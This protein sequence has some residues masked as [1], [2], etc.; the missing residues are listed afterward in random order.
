MKSIIHRSLGIT[1][2]IIIL[3]AR[4]LGD[5]VTYTNYPPLPPEPPGPPCTSR[6]CPINLTTGS[7]W[8]RMTD[9]AIP[10][11]G[12]DLILVRTYSS[13]MTLENMPFGSG[14]T[15][16]LDPR[17]LFNQSGE[18]HFLREDGDIIQLRENVINRLQEQGL[19]SSGS[20]NVKIE[21]VHIPVA[22]PSI[23]DEDIKLA[24]LS[25]GWRLTFPGFVYMDFNKNGLIRRKWNAAGQSLEFIRDASNRL[26]RV[27]HNCG[28]SIVFEYS[29][30]ST[31]ISKA[32]VP[33]Q[34]LSVEYNIARLPFIDTLQGP[35]VLLGTRRFTSSGTEVE[36]FNYEPGFHYMT[37]NEGRSGLTFRYA[38]TN[39]NSVIPSEPPHRNAASTYG[40][41]GRLYEY[42]AEYVDAERSVARELR[43]GEIFETSFVQ[44][45]V[46]G[47]PLEIHHPC[48]EKVFYNYASDTR[49][50]EKT[51][52]W[53]KAF[54]DDYDPIF[55]LVGTYKYATKVG[56]DNE[57][58]IIA[59][60][61]AFM[62][63]VGNDLSPL[64]TAPAW[65]MTYDA[66]C[67]L[68]STITDPCGRISGTDYSAQ[69]LALTNWTE[70]ASGVRLA[71][72]FAYTNGL[73]SEY[74]DQEDRK[75]SFGY[76]AGGYVTSVTPSVGPS[77]KMVWNASLGIL[78]NLVLQGPEG[79][80][81]VITKEVNELGRV[82]K[83]V[84]PDGLEETFCRD[85]AGR[86]TNHVDV[87]GKVTRTTYHPGGKPSE[88]IQDANGL[89]ASIRFDYS[90]QMDSLR[91]RDPLNR[92]VERY[93][94]DGMGR[95]EKIYDIEGRE[96]SFRYR[97]KDIVSS[98][99]RFDGTRIYMSYDIGARPTRVTYPDGETTYGWLPCG[100]LSA[101]NNAVATVGYGYDG[102]GRLVSESV[103]S[104]QSAFPDMT[105]SYSLDRSG[106][107]TNTVLSIPGVPAL[108]TEK[109]SFDQAARLAAQT[110][111]AGTFTNTYCA[112]SGGL[113]TVSNSSLTASY[114]S[115]I[116]D[117]VTNITY[118][119]ASGEIVRTFAY[120]YNL[121]GMIT[122]KVDMAIGSCVTNSYTYDGLNRLLSETTTQAG[123]NTTRQFTYDL[124]GNRLAVAVNGLTN[125]YT[126]GIGNRL[127]NVSDGTGYTHDNAGNVSRIVRNGATLDLVWNLQGQLL[128]VT[129]NNVLVESYTYDPTG[130][131]LST[132]TGGSTVY[133]AYNGFQCIADLDASGKLLRSYTWGQGIDNLLAVTVY[134]NSITQSGTNALTQFP[135]TF[136]AI[137]D[138]LGSVQTLVDSNGTV[139]E[140]YRYDAYGNTTILSSTLSPL[141]SSQFGN[142]YLFQ[143]REY[144]AATSLYN[145][146]ARW[147][148]SQTG[149]WLSND[150]IG[151]S[152]G[153][154]LYEFC[155]NNPVNFMD[156][157]GLAEVK[158]RS[159]DIYGAHGAVVVG[160]LWSVA[161]V[162]DSE[163]A[164]GV[165]FTGGIGFGVDAGINI[166]KGVS[167]EILKRIGAG[168][169]FGWSDGT[170]YE[171]NGCDVEGHGGL[172]FGIS[173]DPFP[174]GDDVI[175][176]FEIGNL[177]GGVYGT[178]S[179]VVPI[180]DK[181]T[182]T[183]REPSPERVRLLPAMG[184]RAD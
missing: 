57:N 151:I 83:V 71:E 158:T 93:V 56:R 145:F 171:Q 167:N 15:H 64:D 79:T 41:P 163:G 66:A 22:R 92:E 81:R 131:R 144:S 53:G 37:V 40:E 34:N 46:S 182:F 157:M 50:L 117:R 84:R 152:G 133:H 70:M 149:R 21:S 127:S 3:S 95:A 165:K 62:Y 90:Q 63:T 44:N 169:S 16:S 65:T 36:G 125:T 72:T 27:E 88:I 43:D 59:R 49:L 7:V 45:M 9:I 48:S 111:E 162:W 61:Q 119:I 184:W 55:E 29:G 177:G 154:N 137:K 110:S 100:R 139:V 96:M 19:F 38:Y 77:L 18:I 76:E 32:S 58:R 106:L 80:S 74:C 94:L 78:I 20:G 135:V 33:G 23:L 147:Y 75:M 116:L 122:Q 118:R 42:K 67:R 26:E 143:G 121:S 124:A 146:R 180:A 160:G 166:L 136:Y 170:I 159:F 97:L 181:A 148:D 25:D 178:Y 113:E 164:V 129:N 112:W 89:A 39:V 60:R 114:A 10:C 142:R 11:P 120:A 102:A 28:Q 103:H 134:T 104:L 4:V 179:I 168:V 109:T 126:Y 51:I 183:P 12:F 101:A 91:I 1:L 35:L 85:A 6:G 30:S 155:G 2:A 140:S 24:S 105:L 73:V 150:P 138:H 13:K 161:L 132:T 172:I 107:A 153:L 156:P 87:A 69:G 5:N 17:L 47:Q 130:K 141:T 128:A 54:F 175:T 115:D 14:W 52:W 68:P 99:T 98:I 8:N 108:L 174:K 173:F 123:S 31:R 86:V 82:N 176:G